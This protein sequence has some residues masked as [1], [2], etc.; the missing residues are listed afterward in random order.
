MLTCNHT[1]SRNS[2]NEMGDVA[3]AEIV[4]ALKVN[5]SLKQLDLIGNQI[6]DVGAAEIGE[7]LEVNTS[8]RLLDPVSLPQLT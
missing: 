7:A 6:G 5:I 4:E 3:V 8:L 1:S 2:G